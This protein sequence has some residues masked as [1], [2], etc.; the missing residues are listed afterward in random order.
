MTGKNLFTFAQN[1][2]M[3]KNGN[4]IGFNTNTQYMNNNNN[5]FTFGNTFGSKN[6]SIQ[7][8]NFKFKSLMNSPKKSKSKKKRL[9]I[10]KK[11]VP[12]WA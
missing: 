9:Y 1:N 8:P 4:K 2:N 3:G 11:K 5:K 10:N 12:R 6:P 7:P